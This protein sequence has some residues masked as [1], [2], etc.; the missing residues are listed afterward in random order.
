M[1]THCGPFHKIYYEICVTHAP[2]PY[3]SLAATWL[4]SQPTCRPGS[5]EG[6]PSPG[7]LVHP[8]HTYNQYWDFMF[9]QLWLLFADFNRDLFVDFRSPLFVDF[10][11]LCN[12]VISHFDEYFSTPL[13]ADFYIT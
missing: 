4:D 8:R 6:A 2:H 11:S 10:D 1:E 5:V 7:A 3:E 9:F 12:V 13:A